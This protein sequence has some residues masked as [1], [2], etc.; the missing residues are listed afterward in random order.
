MRPLIGCVGNVNYKLRNDKRI[1]DGDGQYSV[2]NS[3]FD[4]E[5][6]QYS[7]PNIDLRP[8]EVGPPGWTAGALLPVFDLNDLF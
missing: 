3:H 7:V 5:G 4:L 8:R 6:R 2:P 1:R